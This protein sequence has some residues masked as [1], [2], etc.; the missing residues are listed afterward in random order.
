MPAEGHPGVPGPI[1]QVDGVDV[2]GVAFKPDS[3]DVRDSP[4]LDVARRLH[5][6]GA[7]EV[8]DVMRRHLEG[9][10]DVIRSKTGPDRPDR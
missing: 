4:A 1:A 10:V 9:V 5:A 3:D 2:L 6:A 8:A 7:D